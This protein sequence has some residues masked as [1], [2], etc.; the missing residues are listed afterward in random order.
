MVV[1][2]LVRFAERSGWP[3]EPQV[4]RNPVVIEAFCAHGMAGST[5]ASRGTYRS[6]LR[7]WAG[8]ADGGR[9]RRGPGYP[10]ARAPA[11]Y[12]RSERAEL[13]AIAAA[14]PGGRRSAARLMT[15]ASLGAGL[16][17]SELMALRGV[18]VVRVEGDGDGGAG[19]DGGLVI[20][21]RGRR[22]RRVPARPPYDITIGVLAS[23]AGPEH[24]FRPGLT[25]RGYKNAVSQ[26]R[27]DPG[28]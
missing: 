18:D 21:V 23:A 5:S 3:A 24:V 14:Q 8:L 9:A 10:G 11:P 20:A 17:T 25:D 4:L 13:V 27:R 19:D 28:V 15:A 26:L 7:S 6:V 2:R 1:R 12:T 22:P 16:T